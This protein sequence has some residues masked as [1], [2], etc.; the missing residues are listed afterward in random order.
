M[1]GLTAELSSVSFF[2]ICTPEQLGLLAFSSERCS[3]E[4]GDIVYATGDMSDGAFVLIEGTVEITDIDTPDGRGYKT[5]GPDA[6][7]GAMALVL[8]RPRFR[9]VVAVTPLDMVFV[10]RTAYAK[11]MK[12]FPELAVSTA[13]RI[14]QEMSGYMNALNKF[15][16]TE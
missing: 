6:I 7:L 1:D 14:K 8:D 10:P 12:Q 13:E 4:P 11:L 9:T 3:Y 15:R 2:K 5:S 16:R